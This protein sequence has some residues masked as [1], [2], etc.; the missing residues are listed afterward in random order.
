M[1]EAMT[2]KRY[3]LAGFTPRPTSDAIMN[4]RR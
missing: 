4:G 3:S 2:M 1:G